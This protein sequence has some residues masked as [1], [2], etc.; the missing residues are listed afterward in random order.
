MK[1]RQYHLY[2]NGQHPSDE[3]YTKYEEVEHIINNILIKSD[4]KNKI[5]YCPADG[6]ESNFVK[7]FKDHK[8]DLQYK[9]L[10]YTSDDM[11]THEDLFQYAD[12][13]ITNPPFS[14]IKHQLLPLLKRLE[15]KFFLFGSKLNAHYYLNIF[16]PNECKYIN[17]GTYNF[18][19]PYINEQTGTNE[20]FVGGTM[21]LT[22][23]NI[24]EN[25]VE[26]NPHKNVF[27]KTIDEIPQVYSL[28]G[29]GYLIIDKMHNYP[30]DYYEPVWA[31]ITC[32]F[33]KHAKYLEFVDIRDAKG[34]YK[35]WIA[36]PSDGKNRYLRW[37]VRRKPIMANAGEVT[38]S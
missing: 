34:N 16:S 6:E 12:Y 31:T 5:I 8:D 9:E 24:N 19:T 25:Y 2:K 23:M 17:R 4:L 30:K 32:F 28:D 11:F 20:V 37:L 26:A 38:N 35:C 1:K 14:V 15:C 21:Y 7:Y 27:S 13:I 18:I 29:D 33:Y 3:Y 10:I 22:N 36:N